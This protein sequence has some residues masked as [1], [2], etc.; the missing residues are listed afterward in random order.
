MH[1]DDYLFIPASGGAVAVTAGK[2]GLR[3]GGGAVPLAG[4]YD[5]IVA[6]GSTTG[7]AAAVTAA[8]AGLTVALVEYNAFFGGMAT[9]GLVPVWHSLYSTDGA[10]QIIGGVTEE[11]ENR[12]LARGEARLL[13]KDDPSVGCYLNVAA[14]EIAL[15]ELVRAEARIT[16]FL[17]AQVVD[18]VRDRAGRLSHV[19]I[20]DHD[21]RRALAGRQFIDAT[22][23]AT[24]TAR[25]GFATWT[26]PRRDIQAHTLCAILAGADAVKRAHPDFS[27]SAVMKPGCGAGLKHVFQWEAPVIGAPGLTFLAATRVGD[28]DPSVAAELTGG[29]LEAR[30]QLR[31][32]VDA[33]NRAFP[34]PEGPG[35]ALVAL[36]SD[37]GVRESRHVK[38]QYRVTSDD[39]LLGRHFPDCVAKGSYR[40]D[41]H[42]GRGITFRYLN[43]EEH[44]MEAT[45]DGD[46]VWRR[47]RWRPE[48]AGPSPTWY[49]IPLRALVPA[50]A[51]NLWCAGRMID[52][53]REA[54]GALRV[55][56]NCNQMGE[57][58]A[59]AAVA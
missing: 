57:A 17:K 27:F 6:G 42:E 46:V 38:A 18:A 5:L 33:A 25:A 49:E 11:I 50:G 55:R 43:G 16:P 26:Q 30:A 51:V 48:D 58:A 20:E 32:I 28:C 41:I 54:Y 47:G 59:R 34:V 36:A 53:E 15:D 3:L 23:D 39:V 21:G 8:R 40:V 44:K 7:V 14:L 45:A 4:A 13:A 29:L 52:C 9:A 35:L 19:I 56:V 10:Q 2:G 12:L 31:R 22:G 37:L 24:L 1:D